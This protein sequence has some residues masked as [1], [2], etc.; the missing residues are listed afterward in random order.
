MEE[1]NLKDTPVIDWDDAVRLAGH[2][3]ELARD[4]LEMLV[5]QLPKE[6]KRIHQLNQ[7]K[8]YLE[9]QKAVHKLHGAVCYTGTPRLKLVLAN[10]E[11]SLKSHIMDSSSSLLNQLDSEVDRLLEHILKNRQNAQTT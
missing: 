3:K 7:D 4:L 5:E 2:K 10:L 11:T 9:M 1:M 6:L 8:N